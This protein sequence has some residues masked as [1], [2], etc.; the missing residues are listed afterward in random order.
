MESFS[1]VDV[2]LHEFFAMLHFLILTH[3][4]DFVLSNCTVFSKLVLF[5]SAGNN[6]SNSSSLST[7][8]PNKNPISL[9]AQI[10][11]ITDQFTKT[12]S[13]NYCGWRS[14]TKSLNKK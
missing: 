8:E 4:V 13:L 1:L 12:I 2:F 11:H 14:I 6:N 7:N 9:Y 10:L 5:Y 3:Q